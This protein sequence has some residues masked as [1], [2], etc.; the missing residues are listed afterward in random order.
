VATRD[1]DG[2]SSIRLFQNTQVAGSGGASAQ[3]A[4][5]AEHPHRS[6]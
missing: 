1:G 3:D 4:I 6:V 2:A 5:R